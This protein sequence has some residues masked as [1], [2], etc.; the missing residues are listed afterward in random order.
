MFLITCPYCGEAREEQEF[1][2]AGEALIQ[3]APL[4]ATDAEWGD[5]LFNRSNRKGP[6]LE[7]WQHTL[8]C[9]KLFIVERNNVTNDILAIKT[10]ESLRS[11]S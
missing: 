2:H 8:G 5:Y 9:R 10:F 6:V 7:Q 1:S 11:G 4:D 3:R